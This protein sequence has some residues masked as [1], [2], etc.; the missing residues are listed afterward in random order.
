MKKKKLLDSLHGDQ[1]R[2]CCG[3]LGAAVDE[4]LG[5]LGI[6]IDKKRNR[7]AAGQMPRNPCTLKRALGLKRDMWSQGDV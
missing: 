4:V 6:Y 3:F 5:R 2:W 7:Q 1:R